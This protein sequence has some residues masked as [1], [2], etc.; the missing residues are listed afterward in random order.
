MLLCSTKL[1][2]KLK[3]IHNLAAS[4]AVL[5]DVVFDEI[6]EQIES[7]SQLFSW[8]GFDFFGCVRRN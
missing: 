7:N 2:N 8:V 4:W 6:K 1:K 3:A 5:K